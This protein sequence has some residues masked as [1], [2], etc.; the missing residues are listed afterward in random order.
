M[1]VGEDGGLLSRSSAGSGGHCERGEVKGQKISPGEGVG[2]PLNFL[3]F[4]YRTQG[5][6]IPVWA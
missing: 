2:E 4:P 1:A 5:C 6:A 3:L